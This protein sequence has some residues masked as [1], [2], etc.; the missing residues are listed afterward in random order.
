MKKTLLHCIQ[1]NKHLLCVIEI[2]CFDYF[3]SLVVF[4]IDVCFA[5]LALLL[6]ELN[7]LNMK[8]TFLPCSQYN[9]N[10]LQN[11]KLQ[12]KNHYIKA[13]IFFS[14]CF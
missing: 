9:K 12:L 5:H 10:L 2:I 11:T 13:V 1:Y 8:E 3:S 6:L 7:M 14:N 4:H